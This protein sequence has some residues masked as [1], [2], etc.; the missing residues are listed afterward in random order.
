MISNASTKATAVSD[1]ELRCTHAGAVEL[2]KPLLVSFVEPRFRLR[3]VPRVFRFLSMAE[4]A[5]VGGDSAENLGPLVRWTLIL[6]FTNNLFI[7]PQLIL[8]E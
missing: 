7:V 3:V 8:N 4:S 1:V 2:R 6:E 5:S